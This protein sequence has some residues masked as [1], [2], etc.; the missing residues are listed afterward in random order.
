M[1]ILVVEPMRAPYEKEMVPSLAE[2]QTVVEGTIQ[3][4]YPFKEPVALICND[5]AKLLGMPLNR[6]LYDSS[7]RIYDVV[8]GTFFLCNAP[9]DS[10]EFT[11]LD[12]KQK[13]CKSPL[14]FSTLQNRQIFPRARAVC[15]RSARKLFLLFLLFLLLQH[16]PFLFIFLSVPLRL[17]GLPAQYS[18]SET[19]RTSLAGGA[20]RSVLTGCTDIPRRRT[21][22]SLDQRALSFR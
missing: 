17:P 22:V 4:I 12:D 21:D 14:S 16:C 3:A 5:E 10:S 2:M 20:E 9:S 7:G 11:S 1:R 6:A 18:R 8:A 19:G 13:Y 15:I